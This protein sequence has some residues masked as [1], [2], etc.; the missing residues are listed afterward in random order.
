MPLTCE[1]KLELLCKNEC[2]EVITSMSS[3][4]PSPPRTITWAHPCDWDG[5]NRH[6]KYYNYVTRGLTIRGRN[7]RRLEVEEGKQIEQEGG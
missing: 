6:E 4:P 3:I 2:S 5:M 1:L 7:F